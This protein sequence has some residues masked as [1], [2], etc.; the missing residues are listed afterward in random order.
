MV[1]LLIEV[2]AR[3]CG[4]KQMCSEN[5]L[6][7]KKTDNAVMVDKSNELPHKRNESLV[8]TYIW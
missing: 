4:K 3:G 1:T 7:M 6:K 8:L 5:S 2:D